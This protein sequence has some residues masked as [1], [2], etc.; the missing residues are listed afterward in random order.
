MR[1]NGFFCAARAYLGARP[2]YRYQ[3]RTRLRTREPGGYGPGARIRRIAASLSE[4]MR[5]PIAVP[6][7]AW[8]RWNAP[9]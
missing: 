1:L 6:G 5:A 9:A 2:P 7:M 4:R 3:L 8:A